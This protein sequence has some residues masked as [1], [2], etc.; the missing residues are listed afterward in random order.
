MR[1]LVSASRS[2][3]ALL[4][5]KSLPAFAA[6][7]PVWLARFCAVCWRP[8]ARPPA[9]AARLRAVLLL[10]ERRAVEPLREEPLVREEP[11]R[12]EPLREEL[13]REELLR[14]ELLR[15]ELLRDE[16]PREALDDVRRDEPPRLDPDVEDRLLEPLLE[17]RPRREDPPLLPPD[18]SAILLSSS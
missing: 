17:E 1:L 16:P 15:A 3:A 13:L 12:E 6:A 10:E 18:D 2:S 9:D 8:R 14:A 5:L 11:L 7:D 4:P